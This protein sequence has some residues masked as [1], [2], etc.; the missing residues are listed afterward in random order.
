MAVGK[1]ALLVISLACACPVRAEQT[2]T[3]CKRAVS[4]F[5]KFCESGNRLSYWRLKNEMDC[6]NCRC[7]VCF[8]KHSV[9]VRSDNVC[10]ANVLSASTNL[11][12]TSGNMYTT[13]GN[14][15]SGTR[16]DLRTKTLP[17]ASIGLIRAAC[18]K[19][20]LSRK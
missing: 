2:E 12:S 6:I 11:R 16:N 17:T 4:A 10:T 7:N 3:A 8:P 20:G 5:Y 1:L 15:Y 18:R 9:L 19:I 14:L 13:A